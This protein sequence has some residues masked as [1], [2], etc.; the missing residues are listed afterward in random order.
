MTLA[1]IPNTDP[2][3]H[4]PTEKFDFNN[5]QMNPIELVEQ[6]IET[7]IQHKGL[8]LSANQVGINLSV[9][10]WG[11]YFVPETIKA[12]FNPTIVHFS[13][14]LVVKEEGCLSY[15]GLHF[16]VKRP[17]LIRVRHANQFGDINTSTLGGMDAT[18]VQHEVDHLNGIVFL[19]RGNRYHVEKAKKQLDQVNRLKERNGNLRLLK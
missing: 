2:I 11:T 17:D 4:K 10:V 12:Y 1:L 8:G 5:P 7:M 16:K 3:L 19:K 14:D 9:C 18:V 15:P 13:E 6:L